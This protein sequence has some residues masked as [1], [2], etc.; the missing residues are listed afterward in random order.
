[1]RNIRLSRLLL[2]AAAI[3][4]VSAAPVRPYAVSESIVGP[5]GG[6]DYASVDAKARMLYVAHG[7]AV[8]VV[9][10]AHGNAVRSIGSASRAHAALPIPNKH[11]LLIT[12]GRDSSVRVVDSVDGHEIAKIAVG[13]NPDA[14]LYDAASGNAVIMN[15][16][17]GTVSIIDVAARK[18]IG[19]ITLKAGLEFGV[20]GAGTALFVNNEDENEIETADLATFKAGAAIPMPGCERPTGLGY[21]PATHQL[22]S[23]CANGKAAVTDAV[24]RKMIKLL[25]IGAGPDAVIM[26]V[27]HRTAFIPCGRD[28]T[29]SMIALGG[30]GGAHVI[31]SI[32]SE[33]GARTGALD[34]VTGIIYLP[35]ARFG[36]P[37]AAGGRPSMLPGSFHIVV[38]K[39]S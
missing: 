24:S 6:W 19:T 27:Q 16:E 15:A 9:D 38:V 21:D 31:G 13:K 5:D 34:P 17:D 11:E 28:G 33:A 8:M 18:V 37:T 4:L 3:S 12:S 10:L 32:K 23:A 1:M 14:A 29:I 25:D 22:I 35:T 2:S 39:P 30:A 20:K 36:A 7:D 26:D